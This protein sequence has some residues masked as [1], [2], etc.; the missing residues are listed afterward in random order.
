M[1]QHIIL[2]ISALALLFPITVFFINKRRQLSKKIRNYLLEKM[3]KNQYF[4]KRSHGNLSYIS[5]REIYDELK[6]VRQF[7]KNNNTE[8]V[9]SEQLSNEMNRWFPFARF[10]AR[11]NK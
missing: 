9:I 5:D 7:F 10:R 11:T 3:D 1:P 2:I 8:K 6:E 4:C